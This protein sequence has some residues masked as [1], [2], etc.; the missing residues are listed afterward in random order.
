MRLPASIVK[1]WNDL[2]LNFDAIVKAVT[3]LEKRTVPL[4]VISGQ[5]NGAT[6][7]VTNG[8]GF[9]CVRTGV[10][11]YVITFT[12]AFTTQYTMFF[13]TDQGAPITTWWT[14]AGVGGFT[15]HTGDLAGAPADRFFEFRVE[16]IR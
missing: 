6:G 12:A 7:A 8:T 9:A 13:T 3:T 4:R 5:V 1:T 10:G 14:G 11:V 16:E 15:M 2:Q